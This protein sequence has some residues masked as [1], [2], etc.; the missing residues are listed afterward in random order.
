MKK[1]FSQS[2]LARNLGL[3]DWTVSR[4]LNGHPAVK[5]STRQRVIAATQEMSFQPDPFARALRGKKTGMVGISVN[6]LRNSILLEK[7]ASFNDFLHEHGL[8]GILMYNERMGATELRGLADFRSLRVDAVVLVQSYLSPDKVEKA[9]SGLPCVHVDPIESQH[10]HTVEMNRN[11]GIKLLINHLVGLGHR[12]FGTL[13]IHKKNMWRWPGLFEALKSHGLIPSRHLKQYPP[14]ESPAQSYE[15]GALYAKMVINDPKA[16]T[17]LIAI[18]DSVALA[19]AQYL[20][21]HGFSVPQRFS[22]TGFDHLEIADHLNPTLTTVDHQPQKLMEAVGSMLLKQLG[23]CKTTKIKKRVVVPPKL[24]I[25]EST[26]QA[27]Q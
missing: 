24:I 17:A 12:N 27:P 2:E 7:L 19:T 14:L 22:V 18:N 10:D 15:M 6:T 16:P 4:A 8:R 25:G 5:E 11:H 23:I 21:S 20:I 13:G 9:L 26:G 1:V 3:S